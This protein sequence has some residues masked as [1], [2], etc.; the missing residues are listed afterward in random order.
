ILSKAAKGT[1][2]GGALAVTGFV[3]AADLG[4]VSGQIAKSFDSAF[5]PLANVPGQQTQL[6][7]SSAAVNAAVGA[8]E[9]AIRGQNAF[10]VGG[11]AQQRQAPDGFYRLSNDQIL[12]VAAGNVYAK[13]ESTGG[14]NCCWK[15]WLQR[16]RGRQAPVEGLDVQ[17]VYSNLLA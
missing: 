13:A 12:K 7:I 2:L 15:D 16:I 9:F 14:T 6:A 1:L 4:G 5:E 17:A 3:A 11:D 10:L 8:H